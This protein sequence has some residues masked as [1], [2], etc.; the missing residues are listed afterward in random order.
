[1]SSNDGMDAASNVVLS[2]YIVLDN[3]KLRQTLLFYVREVS[4]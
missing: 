1:M 3:E 2:I 4:F